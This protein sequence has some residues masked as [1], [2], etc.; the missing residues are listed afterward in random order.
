MRTFTLYQDDSGE[1]VAE[2]EDLPGFRARGASEK[3]A[4]DK[5]QAILKIYY[6]CRCED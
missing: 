2:A 1:W 5:I 4:L 3:E 6:P